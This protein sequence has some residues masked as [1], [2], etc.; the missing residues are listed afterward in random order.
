MHALAAEPHRRT[1]RPPRFGLEVDIL[2]VEELPVVRHRRGSK[3]LRPDLKLLIEDATALLEGNPD[4]IVFLTMPGDRGL[5][6]QASLAQ[7][8]QGREVVRK[9]KRIAQRSD[10]RDGAESDACGGL[11]DCTE[12]NDVGR[13]CGEGVLIA[14]H[15][16]VAWI[17]HATLAAG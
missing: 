12:Q 16:V 6:H 10:E 2:E 15:R 13:P 1:G 17:G 8:V 5:N 7:Q 9:N 14:G 4:G 3:D 11:R